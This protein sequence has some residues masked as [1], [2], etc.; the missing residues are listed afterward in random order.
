MNE[1]EKMLSGALYLPEDPELKALRAK[2]HRLSMEYNNTPETDPE[3]RE[4]ILSELVP[5][6]GDGVYLQGPVQFDYGVFTSF[7]AGSYANFN[8]TVLDCAPV[9]IGNCVYMGPN[10]SLY[11]ALHPM[12][13]DDRRFFPFAHGTTDQESAKPIT[14]GDDCWLGGNV[15]VC[16]GVTIGRG[17]VIG[18]GSVVTRDI[19]DG[20]FAAGVP[21]R[22][23]RKITEADRLSDSRMNER[24]D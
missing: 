23:I 19:P 3:R 20:V 13:P 24:S 18:A 14:I 1:L 2:A 5:N 11:T 21:C 9:N 7:G 16:S 22:V 4:T 15:T 12:H 6:R 17:C 10:V 8:L